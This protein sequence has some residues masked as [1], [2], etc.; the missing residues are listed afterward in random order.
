M[1][2]H[3]H[4]CDEMVTIFFMRMKD[5]GGDTVVDDVDGVGHRPGKIVSPRDIPPIPFFRQLIILHSFRRRWICYS[6]KS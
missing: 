4:H 3:L 2:V 6:G 1:L 5:D